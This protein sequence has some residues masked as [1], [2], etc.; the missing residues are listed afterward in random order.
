[1]YAGR[2]R[3]KRE[4]HR[5]HMLGHHRSGHALHVRDQQVAL[6]DGR[7]ADAPFDARAEK[8]NPLH[9][10]RPL[11]DLGRAEADDRVGIGSGAQRRSVVGGEYHLGCRR[12]SLQQVTTC[13][14][15]RITGQD[16]LGFAPTFAFA[17]GSFG[18]VQAEPRDQRLSNRG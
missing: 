18:F 11:Q 16:E 15:S 4:R 6:G 10:L 8:L 17:H 2:S 1:M 7:N 13:C 3:A 5:Y 9:T 14:V 12:S